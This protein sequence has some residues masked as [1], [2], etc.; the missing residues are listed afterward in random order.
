MHAMVSGRFCLSLSI[1]IALTGLVLGAG[2]AYASTM[3][4][5]PFEKMCGGA[6]VIAYG[7]VTGK[8]AVYDD[9][10]LIWTAYDIR[11]SETLKHPTGKAAATLQIKQLGGTVGDRTLSAEMVPH[12][13]IGD[14]LVL[15]ARD[16][17]GAFHS[18]MNG[19]Q[20]ALRVERPAGADK[21]TTTTA[22][23]QGA[24]RFYPGVPAADPKA[25]LL[26]VREHLRSAGDAHRVRAANEGESDAAPE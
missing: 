10:G 19:P 17:G 14:E 9:N 22:R 2:A 12:F 3:Q 25:F 15:F 24:G 1:A 7:T 8:T 26:R 6:D 23:L 16:Y 21:S 13:E 20:G 11:T 18:A 4:I 5:M